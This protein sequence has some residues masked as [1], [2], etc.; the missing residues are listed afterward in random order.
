MTTEEQTPNPQLPPD[1]PNSRPKPPEQPPFFDRRTV[2]ILLYASM[3]VFSVLVLVFGFFYLRYARMIDQRLAAGPFS[4]T[5]NIYTAPSTVAVGDPL[6]PAELVARLRRSG[7]TTARGNAIGW[8]NARPDAVEIFPGRDADA[9]GEPGVLHFANGHVSRIVSLG[10][11]TGRQE[12]ALQPQLIANITPQEREKRRLIHF[13]D[14]TPTLVHAVISAEDKHFFHH[15]GFDLFRV[16]KAAYVDVREHRKEQGASTLTMQLARGIWLDPN[17]NFRRKFRELLI[18]MHLESKLTKQ[19]IFEDYANEVY[20]GRRGTFSIHGFGEAARVYF[21][22]DVSQLTLPEAALLA[23][24]IQRPSYFNPYRYP[25]RARDRRN[26]VLTLMKEN[27][28]VTPEQYEEAVNAP[29]QVK[30]EPA[31]TSDMQYFVDLM[32][33]ELQHKLEDNEQPTRYIYTTLD[34]DLQEAAQAAVDSGMELVDKELHKGRRSRIPVDQPQVA[35]IALDPHTGEVKALVGGRNYGHSQLNHVLAMR[36]PGSVF[37]PIV[38]AAALD[39]AVAGGS[40]IFTPASAVND[41]QT[42]FTYGN[43]TYQPANFKNEYM[44]EVTLRTA[45]AHSLNN[46]AVEVAQEVGYDRVVD[47]AHRFGLNEAIKPTPAVA[48]G[49]YDTTPLEIAGAYTAFANGGER[50]SPTTI[51]LVRANDGTVVYQHSVDSRQV[52]DPRVNYLMVSMMEDVLKYG[53]GAAVRAHGFNLIAAGKTG[54]SHDGWFAGFTSNLLCV[55]WVGFDDYRDLNLEG[56]HSALP[57][58]AEFMKRAA[59]FRPYRDARAFEEPAGIVSVKL[60]G[61]TGQ[62]AG[63]DCLSTH[64]EFF[65]QGTEPVVQCCQATDAEHVADRVEEEPAPPP[66]AP[67]PSS[68]PPAAPAPATVPP[69]AP[70][71]ATVPAAIPPSTMPAATTRASSVPAARK[72]PPAPDVPPRPV[73]PNA[74]PP[75]PPDPTRKQ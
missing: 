46:A 26:I 20:L 45:L 31:E 64:T 1:E 66:A 34:P 73:A 37:K 30:P 60:C 17:K 33:E 63:A 35:L 47:M 6:T 14:L 22:K 10:D 54:T 62:L 53:T 28:Y 7:Y 61:D 74:R 29:V 11:N 24:M 21:D 49:S 15:S 70:L 12:F 5:I 50:V 56:A 13:T 44:G 32:N 52:L 55:V 69:A 68:V 16:M 19:Q 36:P 58:W 9:G 71:R 65:I 42:T 72:L 40:K 8:Y 75:L 43:R 3:G 41:V 18:T 4:G 39:T 25:D 48:L 38:Y 23:G 67:S 57:I 51:A 2:R 59:R 27:G